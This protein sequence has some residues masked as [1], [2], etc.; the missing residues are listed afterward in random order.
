MALQYPIGLITDRD[1]AMRVLAEGRDG[2]TTSLADVMTSAT[3][4]VHDDCSIEVALTE[5]CY[6]AV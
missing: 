2:A 5:F 6:S 1:L 4:T 3:R